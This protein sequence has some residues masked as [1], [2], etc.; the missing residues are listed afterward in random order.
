[1]GH[2]QAGWCPQKAGGFLENTESRGGE[3]C[4]KLKEGPCMTYEWYLEHEAASR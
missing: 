2:Q 1:M 4:N 3:P